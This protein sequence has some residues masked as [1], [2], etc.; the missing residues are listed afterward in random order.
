MIGNQE[1]V[2]YP[3]SHPL[4]EDNYESVAKIFYRKDGHLDK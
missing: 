4:S 1:L 2:A 3:L